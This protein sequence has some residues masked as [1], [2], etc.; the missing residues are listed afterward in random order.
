M[1]YNGGIW[2]RIYFASLTFEMIAVVFYFLAVPVCKSGYW[3]AKQADR[4]LEGC[5]YL[6]GL[7]ET[8]V[9]GI[10]IDDNK[11]GLVVSETEFASEPLFQYGKAFPVSIYL[12]YSSNLGRARFT[13]FYD[14]IFLFPQGLDS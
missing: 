7:S 9:G 1:Y 4:L 12:Y 2:F 6:K 10:R 8:S 5:H 14:V 13:V 3:P 11:C